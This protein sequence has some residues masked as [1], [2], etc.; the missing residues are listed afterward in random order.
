MTTQT[1]EPT[2]PRYAESCLDAFSTSVLASLGVPGEPNPLRLEPAQRVC[3]L[4]I[5]GL[6]WDLL[7]AHPAA[8]PFLSELAMTAAPVPSRLATRIAPVVVSAQ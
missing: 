4:L 6:G 3:V 1:V 7:S 2:L 8:A 5:D